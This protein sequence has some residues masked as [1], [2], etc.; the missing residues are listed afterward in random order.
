MGAIGENNIA[1]R[2]KFDKFN[3][4]GAQRGMCIKMLFWPPMRIYHMTKKFEI[5]FWGTKS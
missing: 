3:K 2:I 5:V 1:F 4:T